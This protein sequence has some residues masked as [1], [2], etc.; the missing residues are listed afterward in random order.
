MHFVNNYYSNFNQVTIKFVANAAINNIPALV[1]IMAGRRTREKSIS[2][3]VVTQF[4]AVYMC[5]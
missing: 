1:Q 3:P 4:V 5:H 2:E